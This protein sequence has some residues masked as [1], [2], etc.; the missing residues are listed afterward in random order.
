MTSSGV[1]RRTATHLSL[2]DMRQRRWRTAPIARKRQ[3]RAF[4]DAV[5]HLIA[6]EVSLTTSAEH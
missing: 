2:Y 4:L 5:V 3:A 6:L 1:G